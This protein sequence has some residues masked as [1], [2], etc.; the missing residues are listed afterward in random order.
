MVKLCL[1]K[2]SKNNINIFTGSPRNSYSWV[3]HLLF[4]TFASGII[5]FQDY[6]NFL[7][8][9]SSLQNA[10]QLV[11]F[12]MSCFASHTVIIC[13]QT[14][15]RGAETFWTQLKFKS[16]IL[17]ENIS[18]L[19]LPLLVPNLYPPEDY[20]YTSQDY[21]FFSIGL[22][23]FGVLLQVSICKYVNIRIS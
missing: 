5:N 23:L 12:I 14:K 10:R 6:G 20:Y 3:G 19:L 4:N 7:W 22:W 11:I 18:L 1:L 13:F 9:N 17:C 16:L 21:V 15:E 8:Q 2:C